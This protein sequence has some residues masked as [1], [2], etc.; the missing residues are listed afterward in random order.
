MDKQKE[1]KEN[2]YKYKKYNQVYY[3]I[4]DRKFLKR[5][6]MKLLP[7]EVGITIISFIGMN[8]IKW[9]SKCLTYK[10][11]KFLNFVVKK[12]I[13]KSYNKFVI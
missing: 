12:K 2:E 5:I 3:A 8:E 11:D 13:S 6:L 1:K 4:K 9:N 10:I 7:F